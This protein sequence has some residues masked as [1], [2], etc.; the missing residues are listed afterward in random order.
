M[1]A[2][3]TQSFIDFSGEQTSFAVWTP[4]LD[5]ANIDTYTNTLVGN[6]LGDL[7]AAVNALTLLNRT[8]TSVGAIRDLSAGTLPANQNAQREQKLLVKYIDTVTNK[9]Y[10]FSIG[11]VDRSLVAQPGTDVVDF[12]NNVLMIA[13]VNAFENNYVSEL[14]NPVSVYASSLVGRNN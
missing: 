11:G 7:L 9:K 14:G 13:L 1:P 2:Q 4:D 5:A 12:A 6:A 8:V 3:T 10:S